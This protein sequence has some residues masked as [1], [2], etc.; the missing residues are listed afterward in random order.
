MDYIEILS[1]SN[2][3]KKHCDI[4]IFDVGKRDTGP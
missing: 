1:R 2:A 4:Q 3:K